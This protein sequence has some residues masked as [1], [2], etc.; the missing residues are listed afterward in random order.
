[1]NQIFNKIQDYRINNQGRAKII[2]DVF[3]L[4]GT[5]FSFPL[6]LIFV[7]SFFIPSWQP[8]LFSLVLFG[9]FL[10]ISWYIL[11]R[12]TSL[13]KIPRTQRYRTV[14][15]QFIRVNFIILMFLLAIKVLFRFTSIPLVFV[16]SY[17]GISFTI[18]LSIRLICYHFLKIYRSIGYNLHHVLI[19]ADAFSDGIIEKLINQKEWGFSIAAIVTSSRLIKNKYGKEI[20]ILS[21]I[22]QIKNF[23]D[24]T[25]ID[26]VIYSKK[27]I[28]EVRIKEVSDICNE[29]GV[30]FRL[31]SSASPLDP[32]DIQLK[33]IN[34]SGFLTLVDIPSNR[35]SL[36][37]KAVSDIYFS[38]L[39]LLILSPFLLIVSLLIK[40]DSRG[41]VFFKQ[42]RIGLRGRKFKLYK[43]RS[44]IMDAEEKL[45]EIQSKN[46]A[47]G[48]VFK[49]KD[50]PRITKI[51]NFLR[52][53]GLDE[54]PQLINVIKGEMSL[55]GPRPP[56][57]SEVKAYKRWQLR[58]LSVKPGITCSWQVIPN[59][60]EVKFEKW[61]KMDLNYIDNWSLKQDFQLLIKTVGTIF[62]AGGH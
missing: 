19:V 24:T 62:L 43:F 13:A 54:L 60:N 9:F 50:D 18:T 41:P 14:V 58:R 4:T 25:I 44:M 36:L 42:E 52:K 32:L 22:A 48:P 34:S 47:D 1:M 27:D 39:A 38:I 7:K 2:L 37:L 16:I 57:E 30:I 21:D 20:A 33:T 5:L 15:F 6:A 28:D 61:M 55:I 40:I 51:G 8:D 59:R 35:F 11:S 53:T 29:V 12:I 56:L 46:Q 26:E 23:I 17:V 31:Q 10:L 3:E 45:K 49:I